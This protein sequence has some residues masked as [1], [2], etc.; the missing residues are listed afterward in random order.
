M[1]TVFLSSLL[2]PLPPVEEAVPGSFLMGLA[3]AHASPMDSRPNNPGMPGLSP[4]ATTAEMQEFARRKA[5]QMFGPGQWAELNSLVS[6]E[7]G[8]NP[9]ADNPSSTAYG[10]FQFLEGTRDNYGLPLNAGP[11]AQIKAGLSYINDRY[12]DVENAW[13]F[14]LKNGWY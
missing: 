9:Q 13:D 5:R 3:K 2:N 10:L 12:G 14:H 11:K 6:S 7:S 4:D 1:A 8:W